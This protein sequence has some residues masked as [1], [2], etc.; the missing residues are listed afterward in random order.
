VRAA[1]ADV[2]GTGG[3]AAALSGVV[4]WVGRRQ[5]AGVPVGTRHW[6]E[7]QSEYVASIL[8]RRDRLPGLMRDLASIHRVNR[9]AF[10]RVDAKGAL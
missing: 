1:G 2:R 10:G 9:A 6:A 4:P 5:A 3:R 8:S 7:D